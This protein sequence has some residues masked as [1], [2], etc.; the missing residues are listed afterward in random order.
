MNNSAKGKS[1]PST[2][3]HAVKPEIPHQ[4]GQLRRFVVLLAVFLLAVVIWLIPPPSGVR[5]LFWGAARG[6]DIAGR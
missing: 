6:R 3:A 1:S 2:E 4:E 5:D